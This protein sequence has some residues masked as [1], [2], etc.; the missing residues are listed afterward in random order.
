MEDFQTSFVTLL[1]SIDA[2]KQRMQDLVKFADTTPFELPEVAQASRVPETLTRGALATGEGLRMVGDVAAATQQP[3][4][5]LAVSV[6]RL[7]DG[8][9]SGRQVGEALMRL[10]ELGVMTGDVR[11]KI[12]ALQ[13]TGKKGD[14]VWKVA[15][16]AFGRFA[17]EME[18]RS[19]TFSGL[20]STLSDG[21]HTVL[22]NF[23]QPVNDALK[24]LIRDAI[25]L[26]ER[27]KPI[28]SEVGQAVATG[29]TA[30]RQ[31]FA[32]GRIGELAG[33]ALKV[34]FGEAI[35]FFSTAMSANLQATFAVI[36][37]PGFWKGAA[38]RALSAYEGIGAALLGIF[39]RPLVVLEAGVRTIG[40]KMLAAVQG[41]SPLGM[42][43]K[44]AGFGV[45]AKDFKSNVADVK[46][47]FDPIINGLLSDAVDRGIAGQ[48]SL[49]N[50]AK[51]Y[52]ETYIKAIREGGGPI[53]TEGLRAD[54]KK[55]LADLGAAAKKTVAQA[56][57]G[58]TRAAEGAPAV[59]ASDG[60]GGAEQ[61]A[62]TT[63]PG[64]E[65]PT[66]PE[67]EKISLPE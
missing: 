19:Q 5:D 23:G 54:F 18:R 52:F 3:F 16:A 33:A 43:T 20:M 45:E 1:G 48:K 31:A 56:S 14:E 49:G 65:P 53:D 15:A 62:E 41:S 2:A 57:A 47:K 38:N 44:L 13:A 25:A 11:G 55:I 61:G 63:P 7:Y 21:W 22:R 39:S 59:G 60:S 9:Q 30:M 4:G 29:I 46:A 50:A 58:A 8:L 17:G 10:Q 66:P 37:D 40:Q 6:G 42:A 24:P 34:G 27:L 67:E 64:V 26:M 12:E 36:S 32:D 35:N 28:A 51:E